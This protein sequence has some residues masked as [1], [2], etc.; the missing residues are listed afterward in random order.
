R[1]QRSQR[2][3]PQAGL[4]AALA[5]FFAGAPD[6]PSAAGVSSNLLLLSRRILQG[7]LGRSSFMRRWRATIALPWRA[8]VPAHL[9]EHPSL[10]SVSRPAVS[11]RPRLR[12]LEGAL[13]CGSCD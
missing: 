3:R 7:V 2:V 13:V 4:V 6:S 5:A 11:C 10:L 9:A 12:R 8:I 1:G